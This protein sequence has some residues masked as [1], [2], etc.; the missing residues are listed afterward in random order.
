MIKKIALIGFIGLSLTAF[1]ASAISHAYRAQLERE[2]KTQVQD[3]GSSVINKSLDGTTFRRMA[4]GIAYIDDKP[5]AV[6]ESNG[7]ATA[8]G[9]GLITI[10]QYAQGKTALIKEG[11]FVGYMQ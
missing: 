8:Y 2:H 6:S 9:V 3:A 4:D 11:H 10:I 5:A 7:V 1:D